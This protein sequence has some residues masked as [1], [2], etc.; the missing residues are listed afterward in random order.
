M[1]KVVVRCLEKEN[2]RPA[3]KKVDLLFI[4]FPECDSGYFFIICTNCGEIY[5]VD[6]ESEVYQGPPLKEKL[7]ATHCQKCNKILSDTYANYPKTFI[8]IDGE[9][10]HFDE[11]LEIPD[12]EDTIFKEFYS[13]Y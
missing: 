12:D 8:G 9:L 11:L 10:L 4:T 1:N 6:I 13:I 2:Y 3:K 7:K 5:A